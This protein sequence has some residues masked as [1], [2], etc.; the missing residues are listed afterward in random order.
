MLQA[1]EIFQFETNYAI[2]KE[3][4]N[5]T[6]FKDMN[7]IF[8]KEDILIGR[9]VKGV[10]HYKITLFLCKRNLFVSKIKRYLFFYFFNSVYQS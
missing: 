4:H 5:R 1:I 3:Q 2:I 10:E 9:G 8:F 7:S 6:P